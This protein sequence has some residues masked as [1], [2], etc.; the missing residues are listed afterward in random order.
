MRAAAT[1][2]Q[3]YYILTVNLLR[4]Q[5]ILG[6]E[7]K[8]EHLTIQLW[9]IFLIFNLRIVRKRICNLA[10][11]DEWNIENVQTKCYKINQQMWTL[12]WE[13][14]TQITNKMFKR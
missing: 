6:V 14:N 5:H 9:T 12:F 13:F 7:Q 4:V 1:V 2:I 10:Y 11:N 8:L 3:S